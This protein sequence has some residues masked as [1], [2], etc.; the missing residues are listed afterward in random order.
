MN[1]ERR[2]ALFASGDRVHLLEDHAGLKKGAI[3]TITTQ[4]TMKEQR[5]ISPDASGDAMFV[6]FDGV[7]GTLTIPTNM[8]EKLSP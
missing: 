3:G 5:S 8:L 4:R 2:R 6:V 1:T 7:I